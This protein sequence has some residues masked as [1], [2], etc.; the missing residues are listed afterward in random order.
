M[1]WLSLLSQ[2][3]WF[4]GP[5]HLFLFGLAVVHGETSISSG[6]CWILSNFSGGGGNRC[7][8]VEKYFGKA[9]FDE[10]EQ[11][12]YILV[13]ALPQSTGRW[14][15]L[16]T[17]WA[18]EPVIM[19]VIVNGIEVTRPLGQQTGRFWVSQKALKS[20]NQDQEILHEKPW[21]V[22]FSCWFFSFELAD[23]GSW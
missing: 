11:L 1:A 9:V 18:P 14:H 6:I 20:E 19:L 3:H 13:K 10:R 21:C 2:H 12:G 8:V 7:L 5:R 23:S 16:Y 22:G 17:H 15:L 4:I